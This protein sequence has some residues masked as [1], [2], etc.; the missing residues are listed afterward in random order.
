MGRARKTFEV[1]MLKDRANKLI[2]L[3]STTNDQAEILG[4]LL[5]PILH[6]TGNYRGF[7][8]IYWLAQ[9]CD[10]WKAAGEPT[11]PEKE[12]FI[13]PKYKVHYY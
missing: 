12:Q 8:N 10:E 13:G 5:E 4:R 6:A 9:G 1:A 2:A 7:N 3:E 11:F